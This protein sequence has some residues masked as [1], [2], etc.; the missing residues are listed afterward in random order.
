MNKRISRKKSENGIL[1]KKRALI[2]MLLFRLFRSFGSPP[3]M[4]VMLMKAQ[5]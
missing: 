1:K 3:E 5:P 4:R 2:A